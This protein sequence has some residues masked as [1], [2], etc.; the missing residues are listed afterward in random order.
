M[1]N[2]RKQK[3]EGRRPHFI[4]CLLPTAFCLL[5]SSCGYTT[6]PG[7]ASHLRTVYV[8]P[9]VNKIDLTQL[10]TDYQRFPI[11]RPGMEVNITNAVISRFQFT[12]LLRPAA[13]ANAD[14]RL[15]GELIEFRRDALRFNA[16]QQV[17]EWRLSVVVNLRFYDLHTN[18]L[19]WEEAPLIGDTTYFAIGTNTESEAKALDRAIQDLARR[20]V[21]RGVE[22]W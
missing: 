6:R 21:E 19:L 1:V 8:K 9:F 17:E 4:L 18:T 15:E 22:S 12:G 10:T 16:S 20:V 11:Y 2:S 7:L 5:L 3:A 14:S 13:P